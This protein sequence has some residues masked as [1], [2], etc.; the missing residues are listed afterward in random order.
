MAQQQVKLIGLKVKNNGIIQAAELTPDILGKKLILVTGGIGEGKTTLINAAKIATSGP[1]M[2][3][4]TDILPNDFLSEALLVDGEVPIF[5]GVRTKAQQ[6]GNNVGKIKM[7]TYLYT[8][9]V[10]GRAIQPIIAGKAWTA[11]EYWKALTTELTHSLNDVFSDNQTTHRKLIEKLFSNELAQQHMSE[12]YEQLSSA[13][14]KR[15]T[16]RTLCQANG[17]YMERFEEEGYRKDTLDNLKKIDIKSIEKKIIQAEIEKATAID[18]SNKEYKLKCN[19]LDVEYN[20]RLQKIKDEGFELRSKVNLQIQANQNTYYDEMAKWNETHNKYI[21][22]QKEYNE[23]HQR[24]INF[25]KAITPAQIKHDEI[26]SFVREFDEFYESATSKFIELEK[27]VLK[28]VD[29]KLSEEMDAKIKQYK[30]LKAQKVVYP[31]QEQ[32]DVKEIE[33]KIILLY[34]EKTTAEKINAM[35]DRYQLWLNWNKYSG[36][37]TKLLEELKQKYAAINVGVEGMK[38]CTHETSDKTEIWLKYNG[39]F[40]PKY[41]QNEDKEYRFLFEY[42]SFQKTI[43]GLILQSARLNLKSRALRI[44][45]IDDIAF[46]EKDIKILAEIAEKLNLKLITAWTHEADKD[47]LIEGQVLIEGGEVFFD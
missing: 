21:E 20:A 46:C 30:E 38:I 29:K 32:I 34:S 23:L 43:I 5:I 18:S 8:K 39:S 26:P 19:K 33:N 11:T 7:E 25:I 3:K 42:S 37:Y 27:P 24:I 16:A 12:F 41:F 2:I 22:I 4:K 13:K 1:A 44:A 36:E 47:N 6:R 15:D 40:D 28:K 35:F 45:Y 17:A 10:N 14:Y 9:D 31:I